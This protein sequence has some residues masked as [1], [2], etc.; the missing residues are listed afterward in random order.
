MIC[1]ICVNKQQ[2]NCFGVNMLCVS[3]QRYASVFS[4]LRFHGVQGGSDGG[5]GL[6]MMVAVC[7]CG[8]IG[9]ELCFSETVYGACAYTQCVVT[10][11]IWWPSVADCEGVS[12]PLPMCVPGLGRLRSAVAQWVLCSCPWVCL[13]L[14]VSL[15]T[16]VM[17]PSV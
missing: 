15:L 11:E 17:L 5:W 13:S 12:L 14:Q 9:L 16:H 10:N 4:S 8:G 7:F 6:W 2:G 3:S 1:P